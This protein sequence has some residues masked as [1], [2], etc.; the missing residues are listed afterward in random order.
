[1]EILLAYLDQ[2]RGRRGKLAET[3]GISP[4]AISMWTRVPGERLIDVSRA[5]GIAPEKLRPDMYTAP[6]PVREAS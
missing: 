6:E 2:E 5:T 1:M 4:S 3:L